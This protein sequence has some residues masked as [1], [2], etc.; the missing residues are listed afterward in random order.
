MGFIA[1]FSAVIPPLSP[2]L[3]ADEEKISTNLHSNAQ[4]QTA[5]GSQAE[6]D[7]FHLY[8]RLLIGNNQLLFISKKNR[9]R[10]DIA[11]ACG[12][13]LRPVLVVL[14]LEL[15]GKFAAAE[16]VVDQSDSGEGDAEGEN[17]DVDAETAP[18]LGLV[19]G[20]EDLRAITEIQSEIILF[21]KGK[22]E[23]R[24]IRTCPLCSHP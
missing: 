12:I 20:S 17:A 13:F 2:I 5:V 6:L 14:K 4:R 18:V 19:V 10:L 15:L 8:R 21:K 3:T 9:G 11:D 24:E 23:G 7:K 16:D 1:E 22:Q